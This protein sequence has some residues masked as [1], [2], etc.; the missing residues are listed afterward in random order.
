MQADTYQ[1]SFNTFTLLLTLTH[2]NFY[3]EPINT[4][5]IGLLVSK[6]FKPSPVETLLFA[7]AFSAVK[8]IPAEMNF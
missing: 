2:M 7:F 4:C 6:K 3:K 8:Q 1:T 5:Q